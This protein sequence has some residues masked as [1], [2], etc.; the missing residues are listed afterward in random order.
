MR[1][2]KLFLRNHRWHYEIVD[3]NVTSRAPTNFTSAMTIGE[4]ITA[5][6]RQMP[7]LMV[8]L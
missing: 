3:G 1:L 8:A 4:V 2:T 5:M 7:N 6:L